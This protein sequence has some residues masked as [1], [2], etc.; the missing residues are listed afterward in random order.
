MT[1]K[2]PE[3]PRKHKW[4]TES[5]VGGDV[6]LSVWPSVDDLQT[7][8]RQQRFLET[9]AKIGNDPRVTRVEKHPHDESSVVFLFHLQD[10]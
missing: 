10:A 7:E 6:V 3:K 4:V 5:I 2:L 1:V 8:A 9:I